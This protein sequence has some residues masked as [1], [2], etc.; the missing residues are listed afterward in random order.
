MTRNNIIPAENS[1][2]TTVKKPRGPYKKKILFPTERV[3]DTTTKKSRGPYKKKILL[4]IVPV[5]NAVSASGSTS[6][7]GVVAD[8]KPVEK[9]GYAKKKWIFTY[10]KYTAEGVARLKD[11]L[12]VNLEVFKLKS[13]VGVLKNTFKGFLFCLKK[14]DFNS[15]GSL[16]RSIM[17]A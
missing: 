2:L 14:N 12:S 15:F 3:D 7:D 4:P 6:A 8:G 10:H 17:K 1:A 11:F 9:R 5:S 13:A 16:K